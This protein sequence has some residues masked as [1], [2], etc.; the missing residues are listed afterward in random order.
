[1]IVNLSSIYG[2]WQA[3]ISASIISPARP[4]SSKPVYYSVTK[5]GLLGLTA[6]PGD[7]LCRAEYP[8]QCPHP[9]G[10]FNEHEQAFVQAYSARTVL[11]RMANVD[12]MNGALLFPGL[13]RLGLH[14]RGQ[15]DRRRRA[16]RPGRMTEVPGPDSGSRALKEHPAQNIGFCRTPV[17][18]L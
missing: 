17:D 14:D 2:R 3:P 7:L 12:E 16:G 15:P 1:V 13:G 6:L 8:R 9:G 4:P 18:R 10:V 11:G 5:A